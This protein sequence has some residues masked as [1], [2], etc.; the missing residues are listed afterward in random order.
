MLR[1]ISYSLL[2]AFGTPLAL[3]QSSTLMLR[4]QSGPERLSL[5]FAEEFSVKSQATERNYRIQTALIG[6]EPATGYPVLFVLDGDAYFASVA[7]FAK[8]LSE[9]SMANPDALSLLIVGV[10]YSDRQ[11]LDLKQRALDYTPPLRAEA[12]AEER[13]KFGQGALFHRFLNEELLDYL[14][15]Q[16]RIDNA[17]LAL[18]GHS[19]GGLYGLYDL[20]SKDSRFNYYVLSSPSIWWHDSRVLD[21]VGDLQQLRNKHVRISIGELEIEMAQGD[22]RRRSRDMA[23]QARKLYA[24]LEDN[25]IAVEWGIYPNETHG[26]VAYKSVLDSL[27]F[28]QH[29]IKALE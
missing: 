17:H 22:E 5:S 29:N 3:A 13:Q 7:T 16:Y 10:G 6:K 12:S 25:G 18:Y 26:T 1:A 28:L 14:G 15:T 11:R 9:A 23:G 4:L 2:I 19:F 20:L 24:L 27:R 21:F 8:A